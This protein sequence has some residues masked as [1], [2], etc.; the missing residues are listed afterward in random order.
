MGKVI[1]D[2]GF[3]DFAGYPGWYGIEVDENGNR[4]KGPINFW[5][6]FGL[7]FH[8]LILFILAIGLPLM[9]LFWFIEELLGVPH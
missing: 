5:A 4:A 1:R 6:L 7:V 9:V 2:S 8:P 3:Q